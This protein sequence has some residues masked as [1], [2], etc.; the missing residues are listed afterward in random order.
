MIGNSSLKS[1]VKLFIIDWSTK[2]LNL[3][4]SW[5]HNRNVVKKTGSDVIHLTSIYWAPVRYLMDTMVNKKYCDLRLYSLQCGGLCSVMLCS[6]WGFVVWFNLACHFAFWF[7][8]SICYFIYIIHRGLT[9][10][11]SLPSSC[12]H[13]V[14]CSLIKWVTATWI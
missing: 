12:Q 2:I 14:V 10:S 8:C 5:I 7:G 6:I 1:W 4:Q 13:E 11:Y 3:S 9:Y